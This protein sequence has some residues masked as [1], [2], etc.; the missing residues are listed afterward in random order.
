VLFT[1][2]LKRPHH[3]CQKAQSIDIKKSGFSRARECLMARCRRGSH[4]RPRADRSVH[5]R[6]VQLCRAVYKPSINIWCRFTPRRRPCSGERRAAGWGSPTGAP[7]CLQLGSLETAHYADYR[8]TVFHYN[9]HNRKHSTR[10][11]RPICT[12]S[13]HGRLYHR[14]RGSCRLPSSCMPRHLL[15]D[16]VV[17]HILCESLF[18]DM[19]AYKF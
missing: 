16:S 11:T 15:S 2:A 19:A 9:R 6:A 4:A 10:R 12:S 3:E 18:T 1:P 8:P 14:G 5:D 13:M 7:R 17:P